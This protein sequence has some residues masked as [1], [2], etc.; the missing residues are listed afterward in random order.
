MTVQDRETTFE[1]RLARIRNDIYHRERTSTELQR[2]SEFA[3]RAFTAFPEL[4]EN[5]RGSIV[6]AA[7]AL[8]GSAL[9][10][11]GPDSSSPGEARARIVAIIE[12][13]SRTR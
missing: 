7:D 4:L 6:G 9:A 3:D 2:V 11:R 8:A 10:L 13:R 5:V 12:E 1:L